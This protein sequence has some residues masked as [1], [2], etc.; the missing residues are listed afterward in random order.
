MINFAISG[1]YIF[2]QTAYLNCFGLKFKKKKQKH[3]KIDKVFDLLILTTVF[4]FDQNSCE[5]HTVDK[6]LIWK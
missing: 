3:S 2:V 5:I 6:Y 4:K 1:K